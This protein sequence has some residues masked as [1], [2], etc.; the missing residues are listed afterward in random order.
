MRC[1]EPGDDRW[2]NVKTL[3]KIALGDAIA[4]DL[5]LPVALRLITGGEEGI[6]GALVDD[7]SKEDTAHRWIAN[8]K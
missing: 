7:R 1:W 3:C 5:H 4:T 6:N 8:L 2:R